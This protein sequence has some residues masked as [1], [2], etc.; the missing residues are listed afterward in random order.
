MGILE[1]KVAIVTGGTSG[2]G[3]CVAKLFV[4]E[5]AKVVLAARRRAEGEA[6]AAQLGPGVSFIR[7][8]VAEEA[9]TKAMVEHALDRFG[10]LDCLVNNAGTPGHMVGIADT[11]I[12]HFDA[13][14]AVH[15]RGCM[16]GMKHAAPAMLRQGS[17]CIINIA[18]VSGHRAGFSAH[19]YSAAKAALIH[20]TRSV[21]AEL[22]EQGIRV[23]SISPGPIVTGIFG[24]A[25][26]LTDAAADRSADAVRSVFAQFQPIYQPVPRAGLP[27]DVAATALF[28]ASDGAR[29]HHRARHRRGRWD[30]GWATVFKGP[31]RPP[32]VGTS[33]GCALAFRIR[34]GSRAGRCL[35][36]HTT[37]K[38]PNCH[39]HDASTS[40]GN[41]NP[42]SCSGVQSLYAP[43]M[44]PRYGSATASTR[45]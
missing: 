45:A 32:R 21:A 6:S 44:S 33:S 9:D 7:T 16:L 36:R 1:G 42:R 41:S 39:G 22:G 14:M 34:N 2:I 24:K 26:G 11:Q 29:I 12:A 5:G 15:V 31:G 30:H 10:K 27:E 40:S 8:D 19:S 28:L 17:G 43:T 38:L 4:L 18:S 37:R 3:A 25:A 35:C 13:I 20:L 23:N